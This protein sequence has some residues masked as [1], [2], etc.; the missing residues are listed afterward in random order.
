MLTLLTCQTH[1]S[2]QN[3]IFFASGLHCF[4]LTHQNLLSPLQPTNLPVRGVHTSHLPPSNL[5]FSFTVLF[6][7]HKFWKGMKWSNF[8]SDRKRSKKVEKKI[9][10]CLNK[11]YKTQGRSW[12]NIFMLFLFTQS[13]S[14]NVS[15]SFTNR[16]N[17]ANF[18]RAWKWALHLK[19][20]N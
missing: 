19:A 7:K 10:T 1:H 16:Y 4:S 18:L 9:A 6:L 5:R 3:D 14:T 12:I 17:P 13:C 2:S 8:L 15:L 11:H 20:A